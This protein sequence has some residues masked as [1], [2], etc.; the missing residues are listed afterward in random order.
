MEI[1]ETRLAQMLTDLWD[2]VSDTS[3][4]EFTARKNLKEL[5]NLWTR[6]CKGIRR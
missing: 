3:C 2:T 4:T 5:F 6:T 1:Y